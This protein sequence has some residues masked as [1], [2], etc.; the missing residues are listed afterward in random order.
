MINQK[1]EFFIDRY[2]NKKQNI[3]TRIS[4]DSPVLLIIF[5]I[6]MSRVL[7]KVSESCLLIIFY[8]LWI[9]WDL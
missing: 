1:I 3:K 7:E 5:F 2:D 9:T 6:Y 8:L 4:N